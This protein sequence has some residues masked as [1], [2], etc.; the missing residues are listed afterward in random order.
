MLMNLDIFEKARA[1]TL[2]HSIDAAQPGGGSGQDRRALLACV[3]QVSWSF[4][5]YHI[6]VTYI[7][8][9]R[10][11]IPRPHRRAVV[12]KLWCDVCISHVIW[13]DTTLF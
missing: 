12:T 4:S 9:Q 11:L 2:A 6:L 3:V 5:L 10:H 13:H 1:V 8:T 7:S